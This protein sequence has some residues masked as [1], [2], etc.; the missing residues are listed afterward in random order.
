MHNDRGALAPRL[1]TQRIPAAR[2][3]ADIAADAASGLAGRPRSMPPKYFYD[4]HGS[5]LFDAICETPEYYP[6]RTEEALLRAHAGTI[7]A[8]AGPTHI[9]EFGSGTARK[10]RHLLD[11]WD[12]SPQ[13]SVYWPFDVCEAMLLESGRELVRDYGELRVNALVGDYLGGLQGLPQLREPCLF[14]FLGGTIGNFTSEQA[15]AFLREVRAIMKPQDALLL[16]ADR[17]KRE[18]LL[19]AA[20]NDNQGITAQFN[21]NLLRV[22]NRELDADFSLERFEHR[23]SF[24]PLAS[25]IE[26]Y[27]VSRCD[28]S[29]HVG[30]LEETLH[31]SRGETIL[32]EISRKFTP[33][34]LED[35]LARAGFAVDDH[36]EPDNGFFSLV[37]ARPV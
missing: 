24:N 18:D 6:T 22:L 34:R 14:L 5:R 12:M 33:A 36:L 17:V 11:A 10:T 32:T 9:V 31:F 29:V 37:L 30:A 8:D 26:M 3:V 27:L 1:T 13:A 23:A 28:Q 7:I 19:H 21:L 35:L 20:Y 16:G 15:T 4:E 2:P 25:Q